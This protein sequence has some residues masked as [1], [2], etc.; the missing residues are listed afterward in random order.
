MHLVYLPWFSSSY[1][2]S[3]SEY[4]IDFAHH[5]FEHLAL[6]NDE[7]SLSFQV[8]IASLHLLPLI[9]ELFPLALNLTRLLLHL[10]S[11]LLHFL[12]F[13]LHFDK[14]LLVLF[15]GF[16]EVKILRLNTVVFFPQILSQLE[17]EICIWGLV[18]VIVHIEKVRVL[19][20]LLVVIRDC[21]DC[22]WLALW[23]IGIDYQVLLWMR[24]YWG[25]CELDLRGV[26]LMLRCLKHNLLLIL[27]G[28]Y[29]SLT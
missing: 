14:V 22:N 4:V 8:D 6:L 3:I 2:F 25:L 10:L 18:V 28:L 16:F 13:V 5:L 9:L 19:L 12:F 23:A 7:A 20:L 24:C 1:L 15:K 26:V 29:V 21:G 27:L 17:Q 11:H